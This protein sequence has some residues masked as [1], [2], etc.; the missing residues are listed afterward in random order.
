VNSQSQAEKSK[1][2][3]VDS[4]RER[5]KAQGS[6]VEV[7]D[8]KQAGLLSIA[9]FKFLLIAIAVLLTSKSLSAN[10]AEFFFEKMVQI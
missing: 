4:L 7:R 5:G 9:V 2:V 10:P 1:G 6:Y 8:A 3:R